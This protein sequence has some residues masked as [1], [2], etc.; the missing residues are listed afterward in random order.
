[1]FEWKRHEWSFLTGF[2][3]SEH[4]H[5]PTE[6]Q[7]KHL[8]NMYMSPTQ[9][10]ESKNPWCCKSLALSYRCLCGQQSFCPV[11]Q[12]RSRPVTL[13][14]SWAIGLENASILVSDKKFQKTSPPPKKKKWICLFAYFDV[15]FSFIDVISHQ[16][17]L[18]LETLSHWW[19]R[20]ENP[21]KVSHS[22]LPLLSGEFLGLFFAVKMVW[23][24]KGPP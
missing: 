16:M 7:H 12:I 6:F 1:M 14:V 22:P 18:C 23:Y 24:K 10:C 19:S 21:P 3:M 15:I 4:S 17:T 20:A 9:R 11:S 13:E 8:S 5:S 2:M